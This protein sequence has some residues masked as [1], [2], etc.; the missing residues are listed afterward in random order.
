MGSLRERFL[1][2]KVKDEQESARQKMARERNPGR[3]IKS[4]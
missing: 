3:K 2:W 4:M 1:C